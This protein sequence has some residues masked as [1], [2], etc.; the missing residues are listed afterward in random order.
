MPHGLFGKRYDRVIESD[1]Q[2]LH[3][4]FRQ[5]VKSIDELGLVAANNLYQ[6]MGL[7]NLGNERI[8][9]DGKL[10]VSITGNLIQ[11]SHKSEL[12][13]DYL[14]RRTTI[15]AT[16]GLDPFSTHLS[17]EE[18]KA[19]CKRAEF[20]LN[21]FVKVVRSPADPIPIV[22]ADTGVREEWRTGK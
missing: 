7:V 15:R 10:I 4:H 6:S 20:D 22:P 18:Q 16:I 12:A 5:G 19:I 11:F 17:P 14:R 8:Y 2:D 13:A 9:Q 3:Y 21:Y 1:K